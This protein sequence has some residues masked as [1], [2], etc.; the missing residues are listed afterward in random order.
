MKLFFMT[1]IIKLL[2][3]DAVREREPFG[4]LKAGK[5]RFKLQ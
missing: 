5:A 2:E 3:V 4:S 1:A